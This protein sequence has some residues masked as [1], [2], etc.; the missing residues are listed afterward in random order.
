MQL[1][2]GLSGHQCFYQ[3]GGD[4]SFVED[5]SH[6]PGDRHVEFV[7]SGEGEDCL[8]GLDPFGHHVHLSDDLGKWASLTEF[9]SNP[10]V[11]ALF[12]EARGHEVSH[13]RQPRKGQGVASQ[14]DAEPSEFGERSCHESR[15]R[16]V[17]VTEAV[18]HSGGDRHDVLE[19]TGRFASGHIGVGVDPECRPHQQAL[20]LRCGFLFLHGDDCSGGLTL[21]DFPGEVRS[22][23]HPH[24]LGVSCREHLA[25]HFGHPQERPTFD[26]FGDAQDRNAGGDEGRRL[27]ED[28]AKAV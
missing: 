26:A 4:P 3:L 1:R 20:E 10:T 15:H 12:A 6:E 13:A 8:R 2:L 27:F 16:V 25:D 5:G 7:A 11:A 22:G 9:D 17:A 24:A 21:G 19:G 14:C 28:V 18:C 23:E